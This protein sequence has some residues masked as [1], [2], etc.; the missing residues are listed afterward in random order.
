MADR[1]LAQL[2]NLPIPS[3]GIQTYALDGAQSYRATLDRLIQTSISEYGLFTSP[4][5][6]SVMSPA[7]AQVLLDGLNNATTAQLNVSRVNIDLSPFVSGYFDID[8]GTFYDTYANSSTFDG[9][10]F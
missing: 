7:T 5:N 1:T 3:T 10:T 9:G 8:G 6:P 2:P 4:L